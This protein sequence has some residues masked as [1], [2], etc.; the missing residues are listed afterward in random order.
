MVRFLSSNVVVQCWLIVQLLLVQVLLQNLH[1]K[2]KVMV[3][4]Q[5]LEYTNVVLQNQRL[6]SS[7]IGKT[8]L[9]MERS[10]LADVLGSDGKALL[11]S[12]LA[13]LSHRS[14]FFGSAQLWL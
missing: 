11:G 13:K 12:A 3:D 14:R 2:P 5:V 8:T 7:F 4:L 10:N 6:I 9:E 1:L